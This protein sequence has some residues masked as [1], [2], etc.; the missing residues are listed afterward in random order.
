MSRSGMFEGLEGVVEPSGGD[1]YEA[2]SFGFDLPLVN[3][4]MQFYIDEGFDRVHTFY[5]GVP[6]KKTADSRRNGFYRK[7]KGMLKEG[8]QEGFDSNVFLD[9][10]IERL[11]WEMSPHENHPSK[12][13]MMLDTLVQ[14]LYNLG[15]N[16]FMIDL[17]GYQQGRSKLTMLGRKIR[18]TKERTLNA[19]YSGMVEIFGADSSY[20]HLTFQ[21]DVKS[22]SHQARFNTFDY[23]GSIDFLGGHPKGCTFNLDSAKPIVYSDGAQFNL[24][25]VNLDG[26]GWHNYHFNRLRLNMKL[27][28]LRGKGFFEQG[29]IIHLHR[30]DEIEEVMW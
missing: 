18:G 23:Y 10:M 20:C 3:S 7:L 1:S 5:W 13:G 26:W 19:T 25:N 29:N 4:V 22:G 16:D 9:A 21:G 2:G 27:S 15:Q 30:G 24:F 28:K 8:M 14:A 17:Q 11:N 6:H 12:P